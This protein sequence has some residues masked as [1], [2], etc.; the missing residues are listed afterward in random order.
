MLQM[1]SHR[2]GVTEYRTKVMQLSVG[3]VFTQCPLWFNCPR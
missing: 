1:L 3:S 2:L